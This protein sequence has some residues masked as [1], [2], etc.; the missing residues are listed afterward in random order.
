MKTILSFLFLISIPLSAQERNKEL[1]TRLLESLDFE[2]AIID[3]GDSGFAAVKD[4]LAPH[5][6]NDK[7]MAEVKD[8][9]MAYMTRLASDPVLKEKSIAA[10]QK[11]FTDVELEELILFYQTPLGKKVNQVQPAITGEIMQ[12]SMKLAEKHV[13]PF[14]EALQDILK[15][16]GDKELEE[17]KEKESK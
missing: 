16:K 5:D 4:S 12:F 10:Y 1:A 9:F 6:L 15:R 11:H 13:G 14:Q 2:Q 8:A 3:T 17:E 7:E